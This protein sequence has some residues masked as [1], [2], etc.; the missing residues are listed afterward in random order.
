MKKKKM[1]FFVVI[2][3]LFGLSG[4]GEEKH[5]PIT[6]YLW[7]SPMM[8]ELTPWLEEQFA[9]IDF[10]FVVGQNSMDY[11]VD[12]KERGSMPDIITCRR[13]SLNDVAKLSDDLMDFR[14]SN[15]VGSFYDGYIENNREPGGAVRWL[16][17]GAEVDGYIANMDLFEKY[18][19]AIPTNEKE[20]S[21]VCQEFEQFGIRGY[22]NDYLMDYSCMEALQGAGISELTSLDGTLWRR[23]YENQNQDL[24][25]SLMNVVWPQVFVKF[26]Q[27]LKDTRV[28]P[29]DLELDCMVMY[30]ALINEKCAIMRGTGGDCLA[31]RKKGFNTVM[32]PYYGETEEDNWILTYPIFQVAVNKQVEQDDK[33]KKAVM[34]VLEAMFSEEGQKRAAA[35]NAILTYN[36]NVNFELSDA[37]CEIQDSIESNRLY[38]RLASTEMFQVSKEVVRNMILEEYNAKEAYEDFRLNLMETRKKE[39]PPVFMTQQ[40]G[41]PYDCEGSEN[42]AASSVLNTIRKRSKDDVIIGFSGIVTSPVFTGGYTET[43]IRYLVETKSRM[44]QAKLTGEELYSLMEWLVNEKEDGSNPV[45]HKNLLPVTSG[46]EY[47]IKKTKEGTFCMSGLYIN[48]TPMEME[49]VYTVTIAGDL[50]FIENPLYCNCPLQEN[51][52]SQFQL[53]E[54]STTDTL[55]H[56]LLEEH[57][58]AEPTAYLIE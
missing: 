20:F 40:K 29:Q 27:Y 2:L 34:R 45:H 12:L 23:A 6:L 57:Q 53:Q 35:C 36:K 49:H 7:D 46:M 22:L 37:F 43:Q 15:L 11:Y 26:E 19:I 1:T 28:I 31:I 38:M 58:F 44:Y 16:P 39:V 18:H 47:Q 55:L 33:K 5:I 13:F 4:C 48:G 51:L 41:Y 9:D 56:I 25:E 3:L 24:E 32:L 54:Q 50:D 42:M 17:L 10:T 52:K 8:K 14:E 30:D 21:E